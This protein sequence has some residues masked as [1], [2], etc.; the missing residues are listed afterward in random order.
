MQTALVLGH[1]SRDLPTVWFNRDRR[2]HPGTEVDLD[3]VPRSERIG[4]DR[5]LGGIEAV[6]PVG[7]VPLLFQDRAPGQQMIDEMRGQAAV[8]MV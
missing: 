4:L 3:P 5:H 2:H 8:T 7:M 6:L 1:L